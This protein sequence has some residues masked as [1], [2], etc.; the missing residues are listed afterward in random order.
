MTAVF[1]YTTCLWLMIDWSSRNCCSEKCKWTWCLQRK[2]SF[3]FDVCS[4]SYIG[5]KPNRSIEIMSNYQT[6]PKETIRWIR[7]RLKLSTY[8]VLR[9][10]LYPRFSCLKVFHVLSWYIDWGLVDNVYWLML[11][12]SW[13]NA[14]TKNTKHFQDN[15]NVIEITAGLSMGAREKAKRSETFRTSQYKRKKNR[16][17]L[18]KYSFHLTW[19]DVPLHF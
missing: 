4:I 13:D 15:P 14:P 2:K 1:N 11:Y 9:T 16:I 12:Q 18:N 3:M 19:L 17:S 7:S 5:Q 8:H 10:T 6:N